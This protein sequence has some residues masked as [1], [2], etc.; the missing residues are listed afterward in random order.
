MIRSKDLVFHNQL[1]LEIP[2]PPAPRPRGTK[3]GISYYPKVYND[4]KKRGAFE[5]KLQWQDKAPIDKPIEI[6]IFFLCKKPKSKIRKTTAN[7]RK[8]R[9]R[10][11]G[12]LDNLIK[13]VL[14][15]LQDSA[16]IENDRLIYSIKAE[17][18]YAGVQEEPLT[19]IKINEVIKASYVP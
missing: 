2:V 3:R 5:L 13:S 15:I 12:D 9:Y 19:T 17:A 11:R 1:Y 7:H 14:D 4:F 18:W 16:V 6:E 8:P 10:A